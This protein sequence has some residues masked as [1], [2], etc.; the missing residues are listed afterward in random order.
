MILVLNMIVV[1]IEEYFEEMKT[2][3]IDKTEWF[4]NMRETIKKL[5]QRFLFI[6]LMKNIHSINEKTIMLETDS[7]V[8][9]A[10]VI[11]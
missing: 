8:F 6:A 7:D 11:K 5:K 3:F 2:N 1:V 9:V 10:D 4:W